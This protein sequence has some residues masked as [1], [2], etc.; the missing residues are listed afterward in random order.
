MP[1]FASTVTT[2]VVF[3]PMFLSSASRDSCSF[4]SRLRLPLPCSLHFR[5][6]D[7]DPRAL[8]SFLK[9]NREHTAPSLP[10]SCVSCGGASA[11]TKPSMRVRTQPALGVGPSP[12]V[13]VRRRRAVRQFPSRS[14]PLSGPISAG[15]R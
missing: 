7:G 14:C 11:G 10:G 5:L 3:L 12:H 9:S 2:V 8:L 6:T 1:I 13:V 15:V 4:R